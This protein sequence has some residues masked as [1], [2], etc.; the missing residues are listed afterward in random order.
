MV[1]APV[2]FVLAI[3]AIA[4]KKMPCHWAALLGG[5]LLVLLGVLTPADALGSIN[6]EIL[7]LL[8]GMFVLVSIL[9]QSGSFSRLTL[10]ALRIFGY[11]PDPLFVI[12]ILLAAVLA[13]FM[14]GIAVILL[15]TALTLQLCL[16]L[17]LNPLPLVIAEACAA[18]APNFP[19]PALLGAALMLALFYA[20]NRNKLRKLQG[21]WTPELISAIDELGYGE[22]QKRLA[23]IGLAG[24]LAAIALLIA[25]PFVSAWAGVPFSPALAVLL[26]AALALLFVP[27]GHHRQVLLQAD[28]AS[29]LFFAGLFLMIAGLEK[30]GAFSLAAGALAQVAWGAQASALML[31]WGPGLADGLV[32]WSLALGVDMSANRTLIGAPLSRPAG[33]RVAIGQGL[34]RLR[35]QL[36]GMKVSKSS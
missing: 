7:G 31:R 25:S 6:W 22:T 18:S 34:N 2:V 17:K 30:G 12:L 13:A 8:A 27:A 16:I 24:S 9:V 36:F 23:R 19:L 15:L 21:V 26:P 14:D 29:I 32:V 33:R 3:A 1:I 11:R 35:S 4:S 20:V 10:L 5:A 28:V